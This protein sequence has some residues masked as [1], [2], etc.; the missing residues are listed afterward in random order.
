[1]LERA[2][3]GQGQVVAVVGEAGGGKSR[4]YWEVTRSHRLAGTP[5]LANRA[6]SYG[7]GTS[8]LPLID[9]LQGYC[10]IEARDDR[11][12]MREKITGKLLSLDEALRP[13]LPAL[14]A[15]LDLP[16][17]DGTWQ[18][19]DAPRRRQRTLDAVKGLLLRESQ[20]QP[21]VVVVEDL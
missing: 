7:Q 6:V 13:T 2:R 3:S 17:E 4:L 5:L 9:P 8:H 15:L 1:A 19:L 11:R 10:Q 12:R 21:L 20:V 18:A 16:V 14:L